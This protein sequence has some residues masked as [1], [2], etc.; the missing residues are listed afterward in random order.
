MPFLKVDKVSMGNQTYPHKPLRKIKVAICNH[1]VD[2]P[3]YACPDVCSG[4]LP[5][6]KKSMVIHDIEY[7]YLL[8]QSVIK[9]RKTQKLKILD[10]KSIYEQV[11]EDISH[12]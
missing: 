1:H 12:K 4:D 10:V 3:F 5:A 8:R 9:Q 11:A 2:S 6:K 7:S